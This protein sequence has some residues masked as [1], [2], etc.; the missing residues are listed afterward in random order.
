MIF[1]C[2]E[3]PFSRLGRLLG[4]SRGWFWASWS[5][6]DASWRRS[7]A[8]GAHLGASWAVLERLGRVLKHQ[9]SPK[10]RARSQVRRSDWP[11]GTP[12]YQRRRDTLRHENHQT[13]TAPFAMNAD[14][15]LGC[16]AGPVRIYPTRSRAAYPPP[17]LGVNLFIF[18]CWRLGSLDWASWRPDWVS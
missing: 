18:C 1:G 11:R 8:S 14:T 2:S 15:Q 9:K 12:Q 13:S 6:L 16:S 10:G 7:G 17:R 3:A 4:A 5:I